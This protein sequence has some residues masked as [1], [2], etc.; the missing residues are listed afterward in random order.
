MSWL[1]WANLGGVEVL[2]GPRFEAYAGNSGSFTPFFKFPELADLLGDQRYRSP[3]QDVDVPWTDPDDPDTYDFFGF[4]P[5]SITGLEDS[6]RTSTIVESTQDG[7][8][9]GR[10]RH[11]TKQ[12]VFTGF[13]MGASDRAVDAGMRWFRSALLSGAI[14]GCTTGGCDGTQLC[15]LYGEP[16]VT[17]DPGPDCLDPY[18]RFLYRVVVN[19]GPTITTRQY[20]SNGMAVWTVTFTAVAGIPY[21]FGSTALIVENFPN[22]YNGQPFI[23]DGGGGADIVGHV[24]TEVACPSSTWT[25]VFDPECPD[26]V[27][28]PVTPS[29]A[30]GCFTPPVNWQRRSFQIPASYI[31]EWTEMVPLIRVKLGTAVVRNLRV[32]IWADNFNPDTDPCSFCSDFLI[33]YIPASSQMTIDGR[34]ESVS[35][36]TAGQ[37]RRADGLVFG[38][39][40]MPFDWPFLSC[41]VGYTVVIDTLQTQPMPAIDFSLVPRAR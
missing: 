4:Y 20:L 11:A 37:V 12:V 10:V 28:P 23:N 15:Y 14:G 24:F 32:R 26:L 9:P 30:I 3:L 21:E 16:E 38:S 29:V 36:L 2:N 1:G 39:D 25:P 6:S 33:S 41:G 19:N 18:L 8:N 34:D 35:V 40:G 27:L 17:D 5:T 22:G 13:L 7:G 31:R